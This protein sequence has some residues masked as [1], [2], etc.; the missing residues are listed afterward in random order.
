MVKHALNGFLAISVC[1]ANELGDI[2]AN[3]GADMADVTRGLHSDPRI[4]PRAYLRAGE[5]YTGGTL[6]RDVTLTTVGDGPLIAA[7]KPSNDRHL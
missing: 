3:V 2:C 7:I 4:G 6:G 5:A 1:Y